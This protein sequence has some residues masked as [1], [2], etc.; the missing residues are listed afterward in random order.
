[1]Q[2]LCDAFDAETRQGREM[3]RYDAL[4]ESAVTSIV[5]QFK[6][7]VRQHVGKRGFTLPKKTEQPAELDDFELVTWLIVRSGT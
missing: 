3:G 7:V 4:L 2:D 5:G 1:M 6:E